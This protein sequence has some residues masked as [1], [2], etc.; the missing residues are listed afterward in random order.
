MVLG[1]LLVAGLTP[2]F[3][4]A[5]ADCTAAAEGL[6]GWWPGEGNADDIAG[7]NH[8][9][10]QGGGPTAATGVVGLAFRFDGTNNYVQ[11]PDAP[12]Q[13]STNFSIEAWVRFRSLESA[14]LSAPLGDQFLVFKQNSRSSGNIAGFDLSKTRIGNDHVFRFLISDTSPQNLQHAIYSSTP[15]V[16]GVW[17]H[18][19]AVRGTNYSQIYVNGTLEGQ[20]TASFAQSLGT[21]PVYFSASGYAPWDARFSG[22]LDEVSLYSRPLSSEEVATIYTADS[23]GKCKA[24]NITVQP[25]SQ[26]VPAGTNASFTVTATGLAPL[27]Y[28]WH[29]NGTNLASASAATLTLTNVKS[30]D[31]GS[32]AVVV[33]NSLNSS[34]SAV[35]TLTVVC[36]VVR[37]MPASLPSA[38]VGTAYNQ[39]IAAS[40][41]VGPY[42]LYVV[43]G[44]LPP[45][46]SLSGAGTLTGTPTRAGSNNFTVRATDT[47]R[48]TG[49]HAYT[50]LVAGVAP[51]V[52]KQPQSITNAVG[53][54]GGF[55]C[56][57]QRDCAIELPVAIQRHEHGR[58]NRQQSDAERCASASGGELHGGSDERGGIGDE[59]TRH[60]DGLGAAEHGD[61]PA[62]LLGRSGH[63]SDVH[64]LGFR[65]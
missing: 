59:C 16:T 11:I 20:A 47:H 6:A 34:T 10:I 35:A 15:I 38:T 36:P 21:N 30:T 24:V 5:A 50:L 41:V 26:T 48:C 18:V 64:C 51:S 52:V 2:A 49:S 28:Q 37:L 13:R 3:R 33:T 17:Y 43:A 32:Y 60:A 1:L 44:A 65:H 56:D 39:S 29:F 62:R 42:S 63:G 12:T 27:N 7:T 53:T 23:A 4:A 22:V 55:Q 57:G 40:G 8:G 19:A 61:A 9:I 45:G 58:G 25:Q 54:D 31:A 46:L 14:E